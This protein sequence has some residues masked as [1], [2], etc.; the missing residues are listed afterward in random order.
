MSAAGNTDTSNTT[1]TTTTDTST[2]TGTKVWF[3]GADAETVGHIQNRGLDKL[4]ANEAALAAIKAHR[5][6][7]KHLGVR[8]DQIIRLPKDA[9]DEAGI[10]AMREKLGVPADVKGYDFK[11]IKF[12]DGTELDDAFKD[13]MSKAFL[14]NGVPKDAAPGIVKQ[15]VKFMEDQDKAEATAK[16]AKMA[17]EADALA[18][19]WGTNLKSNTFIANQAAE[20][21]GFGKDLLDKMVGVVGRTEMAQALLKMGQ[22]MGDDRFIKVPDGQPQGLVTREGALARIAELQNDKQFGQRLFSGDTR[23]RAELDALTRMLV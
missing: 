6:A 11:D 10:K 20:K 13:T 12:A 21:L 4:P 14:D 15:V 8:A 2:A 23:A 5:E 17:E 16:A 3:D 22:M 18:K 9:S 7:E 1:T 19:S